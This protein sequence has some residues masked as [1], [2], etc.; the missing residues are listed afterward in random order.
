M[1]VVEKKSGKKSA[2]PLLQ[3]WSGQLADILAFVIILTAVIFLGTS[4]FSK[5]SSGHKQTAVNASNSWEVFS[6]DQPSPQKSGWFAN[7]LPDVNNEEGESA[8]EKGTLFGSENPSQPSEKASWLPPLFFLPDQQEEA[9]GESSKFWDGMNNMF[10]KKEESVGMFGSI[11]KLLLKEDPTTE[12]QQVVTHNAISEMMSNMQKNTKN[13]EPVRNFFAGLR[14]QIHNSEEQVDPVTSFFDGLSNKIKNGGDKKKAAELLKTF[15]MESETKSIPTVKEDP[16]DPITKWF[17]GDSN[18]N[19]QDSADSSKW[20]NDIFGSGSNG[21]EV[22]SNNAEDS[23]DSGDSSNSMASFFDGIKKMKNKD[24]DSSAFNWLQDERSSALKWFRDVFETP[25]AQD[26]VDA[27]NPL[28]SLFGHKS[29]WSFLSDGDSKAETEENSWLSKL[30]AD[31]SVNKDTFDLKNIGSFLA[32]GDSKAETEETSWIFSLPKQNW[33]NSNDQPGDS[34]SVENSFKNLWSLLSSDDHSQDKSPEVSKDS[35]VET[36]QESELDAVVNM[37]AQLNSRISDM[38]DRLSGKIVKEG[39][40]GKVDKVL[41]TLTEM[42][43]RISDMDNKMSGENEDTPDDQT[44][45]KRMFNSLFSGS[46]NQ[47]SFDQN[48]VNTASN[49]LQSFFA[50]LSNGQESDTENTVYDNPGEQLQNSLKNFFSS[51]VVTED[52]PT[53]ISGTKDSFWNSILGG[54]ISDAEV[55]AG[56]DDSETLGSLPNFFSSLNSEKKKLESKLWNNIFGESKSSYMDYDDNK[57]S[58]FFKSGVSDEKQFGNFLQDTINTFSNL[59]EQNP[60]KGWFGAVS[61]D[62]GTETDSSSSEPFDVLNSFEKGWGTYMANIK[63]GSNDPDINNFV[64]KVSDGIEWKKQQNTFWNDL[65]VGVEVDK[66]SGNPIE[67]VSTMAQ[68]FWDQLSKSN[69][70]ATKYS[71]PNQAVPESATN[72]E[73]LNRQVQDIWNAMNQDNMFDKLVKDNK[74]NIHMNYYSNPRENAKESQDTIQVYLL[75]ELVNR[76]KNIEDKVSNSKALPAQDLAQ[77]YILD[78][79]LDKFKNNPPADP[80][81]FQQRK[82]QNKKQSMWDSL[83]PQAENA[84][85]SNNYNTKEEVVSS[86]SFSL[87]GMFAGNDNAEGKSWGS[88]FPVLSEN[89]DNVKA[90]V[91][92]SSSFSFWD[93]ISG[94]GST[95]DTPKIASGFSLWGMFAEDE[96]TSQ[97]SNPFSFGS[98]TKST[99]WWSNVYPNN[100]ADNGYFARW[101]NGNGG[102]SNTFESFWANLAPSYESDYNSNDDS[103]PILSKLFTGNTGSSVLDRFLS[104]PSDNVGET[105]SKNTGYST[106]SWFDNVKSLMKGMNDEEDNVVQVKENDKSTENSNYWDKIYSGFTWNQKEEEEIKYAA[107]PQIIMYIQNPVPGGPPIPVYAAGEYPQPPQQPLAAAAIPKKNLQRRK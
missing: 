35:T 25:E 34:N 56:K 65:F 5:S 91:E 63:K 6:E 46:T 81:S 59:G 85:I 44:T 52:A 54:S 67:E 4:P 76:I 20:L 78:E 24:K 37:L 13:P 9:V 29:I 79:L 8:S 93:M 50:S 53:K 18:K 26:G 2:P 11:V 96:N 57:W 104:D 80:G 40:A 72:T 31:G 98:N 22:Y 39:K 89:N 90:E 38:D 12:D 75:S 47:E 58:R 21:Q 100:E 83:L 15:L 42:N 48:V 33:F 86:S 107:V 87:W 51:Y 69:V 10:G 55:A 30:T 92:S 71:P 45:F 14:D 88:V 28:V 99:S 105:S 41:K 101:M 7:L 27:E 70:L 43:S 23:S 84:E 32:D 16:M 95:E 73:S 106:S 60:N 94:D 17:S 68:G 82:L 103:T 77:A 3:G 19:D 36:K 1:V 61:F 74:L 97:N 62:A 66:E 102:K 49:T 64:S